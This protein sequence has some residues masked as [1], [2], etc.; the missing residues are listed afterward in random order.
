MG[1]EVGEISRISRMVSNFSNL[2]SCKVK[3]VK[4]FTSYKNIIAA[5]PSILYAN[6]LSSRN[7]DE[8]DRRSG[9]MVVRVKYKVR[10]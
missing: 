8:K 1:I 9:C 5:K 7:G 2:I 6:Y 4:Y 3:Y 10:K